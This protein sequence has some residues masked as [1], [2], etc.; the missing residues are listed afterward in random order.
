ML[1]YISRKCKP[2]CGTVLL[3]TLS[4][5]AAFSKE[6]E[7]RAATTA[8]RAGLLDAMALLSEDVVEAPA[9]VVEYMGALLLLVIDT[10]VPTDVDTVKTADVVIVVGSLDPGTVTSGTLADLICSSFS[11]NVEEMVLL[12]DATMGPV[13]ELSPPPEDVTTT[14]VVETVEVTEDVPAFTIALVVPETLLAVVVMAGV[15]GEEVAV[16]EI[17]PRSLDAVSLNIF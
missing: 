9:T 1:K 14:A 7:R 3:L 5:D 4:F 6:E 10:V 11:P 2:S 17:P 16:E 15:S 12:I 13:T 8:A